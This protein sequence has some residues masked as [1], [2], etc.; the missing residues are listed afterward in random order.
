MAEM[1]L[2]RPDRGDGMTCWWEDDGETIA[3]HYRQD[4]E[5]ILER[6]KGLQGLGKAHWKNQGDMRL[7]AS[8]PIGVQYKWFADYG[9]KAWEEADLPRVVRLLNDPEWRYLKCADVII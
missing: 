5:P 9:I 4:A 6:N 2:V 8:I 3:L 1:H 7:E